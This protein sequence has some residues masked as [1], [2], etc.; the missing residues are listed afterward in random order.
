MVRFVN[1]KVFFLS[2]IVEMLH[3][4][5]GCICQELKYFCSFN[6]KCFELKTRAQKKC[7]SSKKVQKLS[8]LVIQIMLLVSYWS[9]YPTFGE[10]AWYR[11]SW[12]K[13][14]SNLLVIILPV[15]FLVG[16]LPHSDWICRDTPYFSVFS[17]NAWKYGQEYKYI[18]INILYEYKYK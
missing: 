11:T 6:F 12:N 5:H 4:Y 17:P 7:K 13:N 14:V 18:N 10:M 2:Q 8:R 15:D 1:N 3:M 16:I 9:F